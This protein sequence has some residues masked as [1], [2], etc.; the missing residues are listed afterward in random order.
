RRGP[1]HRK[2]RRDPG[3]LDAEVSKI[4]GSE[5]FVT[6]LLAQITGG[7]LALVNAGHPDPVLLRDDTVRMLP[8]TIR[9]PPLGLG[10]GDVDIT[11]VVLQAGDRLLLYTDGLTEA[12]N[13]STGEFLPLLPTAR[14]AFTNVSLDT[15]LTALV[16][17]L[18]KWTSS[19]LNDDV[20][21]LAAEVTDRR[22]N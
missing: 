10:A 9:Q 1:A 16:H 21:I 6:V 18:R 2:P 4:S 5:D 8:V 13:P 17:A 14:A 3:S 19:S 12:R 20:A 22:Q 7:N 15:S 11:R